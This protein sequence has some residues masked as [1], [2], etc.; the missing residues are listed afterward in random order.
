MRASSGSQSGKNGELM[1]AL[2]VLEAPDRESP[3]CAPLVA[4][5]PLGEPE[6]VR[7][8][9]ALRV[10]ADPARLR[11]LSLIAAQPTGEACV[12]HL[13]DAVNLAQPT[14]SHHLKV[15]FA[16]GFV[17]RERRGTWIYYRLRHEAL[18]GLSAFLSDNPASRTSTATCASTC[19]CD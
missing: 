15:L 17:S 2:P 1:I 8:A 14:I 6:A 18:Q 7:L 3:A 19:T 11:L 13:T 5:A 12:C 4:G 9:A 10:L 16:A